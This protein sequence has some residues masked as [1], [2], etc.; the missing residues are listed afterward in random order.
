LRTR[1][2]NP[3]SRNGVCG[4]RIRENLGHPHFNP[5]SSFCPAGG[6]CSRRTE[7]SPS[8]RDDNVPCSKCGCL[9]FWRGPRWKRH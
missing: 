9:G 8:G 3:S 6:I 5:P 4:L 2:L 1:S 7:I